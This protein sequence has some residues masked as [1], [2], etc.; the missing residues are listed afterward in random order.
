MKIMPLFDKEAAF[1]GLRTGWGVSF[2]VGE[3][4]VFDTGENGAW[5][6]AN[7]RNTGTPVGKIKK[8]VISHDHWDHK[9]GMR[10]LLDACPRAVVYGCPDFGPKFKAS[11]YLRGHRLVEAACFL[12]ISDGI[13]TTGQV[14]GCYKGKFMPEQALVVKTQG[15][16]NMVTGCA[17]PGIIRMVGHAKS[18]FGKNISLI[19]GGFHLYG[20]HDKT[21][22]QVAAGLKGLGVKRV[23]PCH[24]T[25]DGAERIL[26]EEFGDGFIR[27]SAGNPVAL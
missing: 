2:L 14:A 26:E 1:P 13:F 9:G 23:A 4:V 5:L 12:E 24:C 20:K 3:N 11:V 25:G 27:M 10:A 7:I 19:A 8:V 21:V 18:Y 17:H 15:G 6:L 22:R 16:L